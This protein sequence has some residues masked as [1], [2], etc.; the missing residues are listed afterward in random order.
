[1]NSIPFHLIS[2]IVV[3][4]GMAPIVSPASPQARLSYLGISIFLRR[5]CISLQS[6]TC[7][8]CSSGGGGTYRRSDFTNQ[9]FTGIY[10]AGGPT[11]VRD[12]IQNL[13][14]D[15]FLMCIDRD[16]SEMLQPH[17]Q[18]HP[19]PSSNISMPSSLVKIKP[20]GYSRQQSTITTSAS[21][22]CKGAKMRTSQCESRR[23]G[24]EQS[25]GQDTL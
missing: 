23:S 5:Q 19:P 1:M 4:S 21:T 6:S 20:N 9:P 16:H 12:S 13:P 25:L 24:E 14:F 8:R 22:N 11:E 18:S 2:Y 7:T 10:E 17:L 3:A 15:S